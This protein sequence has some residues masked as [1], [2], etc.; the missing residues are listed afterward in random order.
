MQISHL[1]LKQLTIIASLMMASVF[2]FCY[3]SFRYIWTYDE[4]VERFEFLQAEEVNR[5][6]T[7]I[8]LQKSELARSLINY[9]AWESI[10]DFIH[11]PD[12]E[13]TDRSISPHTF[14]SQQLS[15]VF[16]FDPNVSLIWGRHYDVKALQDRSY[17]E[18][19][20]KFGALLAD[21]LKSRTDKITPFVKFLVFDDQP[22]L[23]ATSRICDSDGADCDRGYMMFIKP[24]GG[25]FVRMLK[26][27]TG[28]NV[29]IYTKQQAE[30][31]EV[32]NRENI[33]ILERL[34]YQNNSTVCIV[35]NHS[36]TMPS[37]ITWGELSAVLA[38][39][40]F[41]FGFNLCVVHVMIKPIKQARFALCNLNKDSQTITEEDQFI[42]HEMRDFASRINEVFGELERNRSELEWLSTHDALTKVGNRRRLQAYWQQ[43]KSC[44]QNQYV[45]VVLI[46]IDHFKS[47]NDNYG[48]L[49][50]DF[51]LSEVATHLSNAKSSCDKFIARY[52]GEEFCILLS[53]EQPIN[54]KQEADALLSAI[55]TLAITHE[56][57]PTAQ[58]VTVSVGVADCACQPL[59]N[60]HDIF[61]VADSAL[62]E[63]KHSGRN[64]AKIKPYLVESTRKL[65]VTS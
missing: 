39:A 20:Y 65:N 43:L 58:Y 6:K 26:Q 54:N 51:I 52:G 35:I 40:V 59:D 17:D 30:A 13:F 4:A 25:S 45:S 37:F 48:H 38:F 36:V 1:S 3:L 61:L 24:I 10:T 31:A 63:A 64:R 21:S 5:V 44:S 2:V 33:T 32:A 22:A 55:N 42:S 62:Y 9:A 15:G 49:E 12:P 18:I 29:E 60:Q 28:I 34:D 56:H 16:I 50:G 46:D 27:A 47:F 19:R 57:S 14:T 23:L 53:S 11:S 8:D 7:V 41:M